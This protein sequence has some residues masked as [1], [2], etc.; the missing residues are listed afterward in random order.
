[1]YA[2][3]GEIEF[4]TAENM[5]IEMGNMSSHCVYNG[6][7]TKFSPEKNESRKLYRCLHKI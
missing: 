7:E 4:E 6:V 2:K 5:M 1:M 3:G